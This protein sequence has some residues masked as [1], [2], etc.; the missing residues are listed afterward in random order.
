MLKYA[1][2]SYSGSL[3]STVAPVITRKTSFLNSECGYSKSTVIFKHVSLPLVWPSSEYYDSRREPRTFAVQ[4]LFKTSDGKEVY[5]KPV[6]GVERSQ[7]DIFFEQVFYIENQGPDF[8]IEILVLCK[9]TDRFAETIFH[10]MSRSISR[11]MGHSFKKYMT[12]SNTLAEFDRNKFENYRNP[13]SM[14]T[15][16]SASFKLCNCSIS[17]QT[18]NYTLHLH[19]Q[20]PTVP[21]SHVL[22]LFGRIVCQ[23]LIQPLSLAQPL[24]QGTLNV[25]YEDGNII[26]QQLFCVLRGTFLRCFNCEPSRIKATT[27]PDMV[28]PI[29]K[30]TR[31]EPTPFPT[32]VRLKLLDVYTQKVQNFI[33]IASTQTSFLGWKNA[34]K[35]QIRDSEVWDSFANSKINVHGALLPILPP[36]TVRFGNTVFS[37]TDTAPPRYG[38]ELQSIRKRSQLQINTYKENGTTIATKDNANGTTSPIKGNTVTKTDMPRAELPRSHFEANKAIGKPI[39]P[40]KPIV[41]PKPVAVLTNPQD[42]SKE[43]TR[44]PALSYKPAVPLKPA[45]RY[46]QYTVNDS[47]PYVLTLKIGEGVTRNPSS[48][49][50]PRGRSQT[51][52]VS[53][54]LHEYTRL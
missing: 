16:A 43:S 6:E 20:P 28:L 10:T 32:S 14:I 51:Y 36:K 31:I 42:K 24:G 26:L 46:H 13:G 12:A 15:V 5:S 34:L 23:C 29:D 3:S 19:Q 53:S 45:P 41:S 1:T 52:D 44:Q 50:H 17:G 38:F 30:N 35:L 21:Q 8:E 40:P 4:L 11:S 47:A 27:K 9:R 54:P 33:C 39:V 2:S 22:P 49:V 7:I 18:H 25:F 48:V 37:S